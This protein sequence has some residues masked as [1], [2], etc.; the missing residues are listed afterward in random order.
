MS[1]WPDDGD[2]QLVVFRHA[3][4]K[5]G[6]VRGQG[7]HLSSEG[8]ALARRIGARLGSF[9]RVYVSLEPRTMETALA[10]GFAVD[11]ALAFSCGYV[12]GEFEHHAQWDWQSPFVRFA[13]LIRAGGQLSATVAA[14]R[15][16]WDRL[17]SAVSPGGRVLILSHG[18]TI[19]PVLVACLPEANHALWG[20]PFSHGDGVVLTHRGGRFVD[21]VF[22]RVGTDEGSLSK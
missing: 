14:D 13:E 20:A 1:N 7:S 3:Y 10:M 6:E 18:G 17:V 11:A 12:P 21:A 19:E 4:T 22:M 16:L 5:K 15:A 9:D 2:R 8:V